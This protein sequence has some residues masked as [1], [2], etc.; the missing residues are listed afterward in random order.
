MNDLFDELPDPA[1]L[2]QYGSIPLNST[3]PPAA[4]PRLTRQCQMILDRLRRGRVGL[5]DILTIATNH[6]AR[7]SE[8]RKA[9][10]DVRCVVHHHKTGQTVYA[11]FINGQEVDY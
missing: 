9:G 5:R 3:V 2:S 7:V 6:T 1:E 4:V 8:L 11:L 10:Y